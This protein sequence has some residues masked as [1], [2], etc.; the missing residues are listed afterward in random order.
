MTAQDLLPALMTIS[1]PQV[2]M[3]GVGLVLIY[4]AIAKEYEP[5]LLMPA[6][7]ANAAG[8]IGSVVA[9]GLLLSLVP[10]FL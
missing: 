8:Q 10:L 4:L 9:G 5:T 3:I 2:L 1:W 7:S 6:V